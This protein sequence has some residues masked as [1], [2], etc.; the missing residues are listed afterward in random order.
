MKNLVSRFEKWSGQMKGS[1]SSEA[2]AMM[3]YANELS[4]IWL[5]AY[6]E[7][8]TGQVQETEAQELKTEDSEIKYSFSETAHDEK[9]IEENKKTAANMNPV[10]ELTGEEFD[11]NDQKN[12]SENYGLFR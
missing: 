12:K 11:V 8:L 9:L 2:R 1:A 6:N 3:K 4:R 10:I 5:G 7:V